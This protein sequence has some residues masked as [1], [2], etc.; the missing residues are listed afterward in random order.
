MQ[1]VVFFCH[2]TTNENMEVS[3]ISGKLDPRN[4][5][6]GEQLLVGIIII[7][8]GLYIYMVEGHLIFLGIIPV[9]AV[10][11]VIYIRGQMSGYEP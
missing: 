10:V 7:I 2:F 11:V 9:V 8:T 6:R 5:S 4:W 1:Y 3:M